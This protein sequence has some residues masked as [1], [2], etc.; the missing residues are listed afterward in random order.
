MVNFSHTLFYV[1]DIV[2]L[3][4][5]YEKAFGIKPK[6]VHESK[7]YAELDTGRTSLAFADDTLGR[8]NLPEGYIPND[9][10]QTPSA[11]EI[12]FTVLDVDHA[13]KTAVDAGAIALVPPKHKPWGQ[14]VAYVR[15][16]SGILIEIASPIATE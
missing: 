6:F 16:P 9:P 12:V 4:D 11:C 2:K 3:I 13:Y 1:K 8:E 14:I 7:L 15:D 5:F 10:A